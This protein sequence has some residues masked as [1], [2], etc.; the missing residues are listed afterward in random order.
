MIKERDGIM[1]EIVGARG[2]SVTT[3]VLYVAGK[4]TAGAAKTVLDA[5]KALDGVTAKIKTDADTALQSPF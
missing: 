3:H 4:P 5:F 2:T 1:G